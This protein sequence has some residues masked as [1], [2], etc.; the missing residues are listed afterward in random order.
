MDIENLSKSQLILLTILV[1]FVTSVATGILTVSLLD[2]APP[3]ITQTVN[4]IVEHTIETV[5]QA[6][7]ATVIKS[8]QGPTTEELVTGGIASNAARL[9]WIYSAETGTSTKPIT[10]GTLLPKSRTVA[11]VS[12]SE[13]PEEALVEFSNGLIATATLSR[14]AS[15]ITIYTFDEEAVLPTPKAPAFVSASDISLGATVLAIGFDGS[16]AIGIISRVDDDGIRTTLPDVGA[17]A[18][19]VDLGGNLLG[20]ASGEEVGFLFS[21]DAMYAALVAS[22]TISEISADTNTDS[23]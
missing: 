17:G 4:R 19:A 18:A 14:G 2:Q 5:S 8:Q 13:L 7:P 6:G 1:N 20:M 16:A 15:G 9:A 10:L 3:V 22:S 12:S 23:S 11:T 21:S